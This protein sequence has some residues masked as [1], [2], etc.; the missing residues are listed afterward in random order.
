[1]T[2]TLDQSDGGP[3]VTEWRARRLRAA[4]VDGALAERLAADRGY[5][6]HAVIALIERGCPPV[7]AAR[8]VAPLDGEEH[9]C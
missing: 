4:G 1:M 8:I 9:G 7:F 2:R 5:D 6:L 3:A